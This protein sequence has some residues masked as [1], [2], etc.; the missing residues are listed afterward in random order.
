MPRTTSGRCAKIARALCQKARSSL[1]GRSRNATGP[2]PRRPEKLTQ[3]M[4][5][6]RLGTRFASMP[7]RAPSQTT[8]QPEPRR[9]SATARPGNT[10]PPVPPAMIMMVRAMTV[11]RGY[12]PHELPVLPVNAK[13]H[14][15]RRAIG[16][17]SAAAE[18]HERKGEALGGQHAHVHA[19]V[20]ER[21]RPEP[22]RDPLGDERRIGALESDRLASD[23]KGPQHQPREERDHC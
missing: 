10:C 15:E 5:Y 6:P 21:L 13:Q 19:H 23:G 18:A 2:L 7:L 1:R 4:S 22:D 11:S 3:A 12:S 20:D 16:E 17:Q 9:K 14:R 8:R